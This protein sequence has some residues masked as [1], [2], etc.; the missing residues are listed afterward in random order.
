[1]KGSEVVGK[2]SATARLASINAHL[3]KAR[4]IEEDKTLE[5]MQ[6]A[7]QTR[8]KLKTIQDKI[9]EKLLVTRAQ[10]KR[11]QSTLE[12]I[13]NRTKS[14]AFVESRKKVA[15]SQSLKLS[16]RMENLH[17][18]LEELINNIQDHEQLKS[19]LTELSQTRSVTACQPEQTMM[20]QGDIQRSNEMTMKLLE[21]STEYKSLKQ[22]E[23]EIAKKQQIERQRQ[24]EMNS[25]LLEKVSSR[26]TTRKMSGVSNE[27]MLKTN[28]K[29][30]QALRG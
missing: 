6:C 3:L 28:K 20:S 1:M 10:T 14:I 29:R 5:T 25:K 2:E 19:L 7:D 12:E 30:I 21:L 15:Q 13:S 22:E 8:E 11:I 17:A 4:A 23:I 27:I 26:K 24:V 18:H 9:E 16:S